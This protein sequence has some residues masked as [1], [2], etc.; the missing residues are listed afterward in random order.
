[1]KLKVVLT[2]HFRTYLCNLSSTLYFYWV[3]RIK[4]LE[5]SRKHRS[6]I[7]L[8]SGAFGYLIFLESGVTRTGGGE[9]NEL[10]RICLV[11]CH[12]KEKNSAKNAPQKNITVVM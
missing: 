6:F 1:M 5:L 4:I 11:A 7:S 8:C 2:F 12:A 10:T 9:L 3:G